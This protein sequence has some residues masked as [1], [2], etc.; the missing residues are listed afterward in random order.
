LLNLL[1]LD[2]SRFYLIAISKEQDFDKSI[3]K[4]ELAHALYYLKKEY[5]LKVNNLLEKY[6][7]EKLKEELRKKN[8]YSEQ[9]INDELH[10]WILAS[11]HKLKNKVSGKLKLS[12]GKL[13][14]KYNRVKF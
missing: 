2:K 12:L 14:N 13:F 6:N 11:S 10:A 4:H 5:R 1:S 3:I 9:V 8:G 7:P